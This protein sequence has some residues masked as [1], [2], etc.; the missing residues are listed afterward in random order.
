MIKMFENFNSEKVIKD[1][2]IDNR[3]SNYIINDDLTVDIIGSF[4]LY[5]FLA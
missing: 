2:L 1:W 3:I 5:K 4:Y